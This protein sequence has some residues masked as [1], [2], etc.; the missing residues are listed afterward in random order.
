M[1]RHCLEDKI[2]NMEAETVDWKKLYASSISMKRL[3]DVKEHRGLMVIKNESDL[4]DIIAYE[5][6]ILTC[7]NKL[8]YFFTFY[9]NEIFP[10]F[11]FKP[12][13]DPK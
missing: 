3:M 1:K 4:A 2:G 13:E 8:I 7:G 5:D 12:F 9:K 6:F 10:L 11:S